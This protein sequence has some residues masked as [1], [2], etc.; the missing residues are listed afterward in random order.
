MNIL[1]IFVVFSLSSFFIKDHFMKFILMYV[2]NMLAFS[3]LFFL[4]IK[5]RSFFQSF[6]L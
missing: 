4:K 3:A 6:D 5:N 1:D 2:S